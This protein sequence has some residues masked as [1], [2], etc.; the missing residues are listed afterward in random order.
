MKSSSPRAHLLG[1]ILILTGGVFAFLAFGGAIQRTAQGEPLRWRPFTPIPYVVNPG[2]VPGFSTELQ[3]LVVI[4]AVNDSFRPWTEIPDAAVVFN[5]SGTS[6]LT[7]GAIDGTNLVSF[8]D[9]SYQF[10]PGVLGVALVASA[11]EAGPVL[12]GDQVINAEFVGQILD[13]DIVFNPNPGNFPFSPVGANN[14]IDLVAV[15]THE[16]GHILGLDHTGVFSSIMNPFSESGAGI[17]SRSVE[18]DDTFTV[19]AL[20]PAATFAPS[21]GSIA[22]TITDSTGAPVKSA[23]VVAFSTTGGVPVASQLTGPD[24]SY[25]IDGM[26]PGNYHVFVEP[27]DGPIGLVNFPGFYSDGSAN[28]ATTFFPP[29]GTFTTVPVAVGGS[30]TAN[31]T[32]S[33]RTAGFANIEE[34]GISEQI[35][36]GGTSFLFGASPLFL[37]RGNSYD[38]FVTGRIPGQNLLFEGSLTAFGEGV[39][40]SLTT[41]GSLPNGQQI[42]QQTLT[43]GPS[44]PLGPSNL[45]LSNSVSTSVI[46]G[47]I[48]TTVNP[49]MGTPLRNSGGFGE[50][51]APGTLVSIFGSDLAFGRGL[52]GTE[53]SVSV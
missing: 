37:P 23:H 32:V 33:P 45:H 29:S 31:I 16:V 39:I 51:L 47:G 40:G 11:T 18:T 19:A 44:A 12:V 50:S 27:L 10:V 52:N 8:Q 21:R 17:A 3:R 14:T 15:A 26:L 5:Y 30:A 46:P 7:Q 24:G 6:T 38:I 41:N 9:T 42:L 36:G 20:Y 1:V 25:N 22:G 4:G 35:P 2:G 48:I 49:T 43:I 28:F 13:A 53:G 34:L